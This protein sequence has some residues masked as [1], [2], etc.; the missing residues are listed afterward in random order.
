MI[1][2]TKRKHILPVYIAIQILF[3]LRDSKF[4]DL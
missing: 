1:I 3:D 4:L 2:Y